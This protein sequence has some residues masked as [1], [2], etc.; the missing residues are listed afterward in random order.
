MPN[1]E[2]YMN[3]LTA[4]QKVMFEKEYNAKKMNPVVMFI[5]TLLF[6]LLGVHKFIMGQKTMGFVYLF[7][8]G[9]FGI[10]WF[11]DLFAIWNVVEKHNELVAKDL[12][13][14]IK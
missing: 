1:L 11:I 5:V 14:K 13:I 6:G 12:K 9:L 4:E 2:L 10:G 8:A 7:T 3:S